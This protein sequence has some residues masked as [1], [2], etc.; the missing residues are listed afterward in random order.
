[1]GLTHGFLFGFDRSHPLS[2]A[3]RNMPSAEANAAIG[4][5][6]LRKKASAGCLLSPL[7]AIGRHVSRFGMTIKGHTPQSWRLIMNLSVPLRHSVNDEIDPRLCSMFYIMVDALARMLASL[8]P[9]ALMEKVDIEAAY[10]LLFVHPMGHPLLAVQS[11]G[12][13]FYN[14]TLPFGL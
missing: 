9:R 1:M 6:Y 4:E 8:G 12:N 14:G 11:K 13:S 10:C 7:T 3:Q 5:D 2:S